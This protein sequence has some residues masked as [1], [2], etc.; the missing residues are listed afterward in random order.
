[1]AGFP[2]AARVADWLLGEHRQRRPF[3][4]FAARH[5]VASL[6]A[7]YDVQQHYV[8]ETARLRR[9]PPAGYKIGL[10]SP[11]MQ[12][13]CG[14]DHPVA[15]VVLADRVHPSGVRLRR[16]DHGRFG[17]EFEL[18]VR[19][20]R[21]L[22]TAGRAASLD[23]V[24][25]AVD[26]VAPAMEIVDDR[27]CDYATLDVHSLVAD[28]AWNAGVVLGAF[29]TNWPDLAAV[30]GCASADGVELG[31]GRGS[32]VLG[33]PFQ[34]VAWLADHLARR[35][36]R[37]RAGQLVMTGSMVRTQFPDGPRRIRFEV[38]GLGAVALELVD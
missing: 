37:L 33:H 32:D 27:G 25:R 7:A 20:G 9:A 34:P 26:A 4:P 6:E 22:D 5:A 14:I 36:E 24:A 23:D 35:G 21:D 1:M 13:L 29:R 31:R 18:A 10:T 17:V 3:A 2:D 19:L 11:P 30:E 38:A 28:N 15:G 12:A 16:H 8:Q